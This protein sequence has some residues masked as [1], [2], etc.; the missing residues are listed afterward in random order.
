MSKKLE[1]LVKKLSKNKGIKFFILWLVP[2]MVLLAYFFTSLLNFYNYL[3]IFPKELILPLL[4]NALTALIIALAAYYIKRPRYFSSKLIAVFILGLLMA[5]YNDRLNSITDFYRAIIPTLTATNTD[6]PLISLSFI[7]TIFAGA[8][9]VGY[10]IEKY[11]IRH[12]LSW[13]HNIVYLILIVVGVVFGGQALRLAGMMPDLITQSKVQAPAL[14]KTG[15]SIEK[16]KPDVYYII[17]DRY[18]NNKVLSEQYAFDNS[19]FTNNLKNNGFTVNEAAYSN[20]PVTTPS[21]SSTLNAQYTK[22]VVEK[23][24]KNP[25]Q[26]RTLYHNLIQQ[27]SVIKAFKADGYSYHHIGSVYGASYEAPLADK[28]Y[29]HS[30]VINI[31]DK[32]T[33]TLRGI[34]IAQF[35]QSPYYQFFKVNLSWWPFKDTELDNVNYVKAQL[36]SLNQIADTKAGGRLVFA[37]ILVPH[38]PF[39]FNPDGS[40]SPYFLTDTMGK[41]IKTKYLD[42]LN[43][44]NTQVS[45]IIEKI[46][47]N[48]NNQAVIILNAD[49]GAYPQDMNN[50]NLTPIDTTGVLEKQDMTKWPNDWL[51]MKFGILQA[52]YIP[53]ASSQDLAKLNSVNVF[54]IVLNNYLGYKLDYLPNCTYAFNDGDQYMYRYISISQKLLGQEDQVCK[55]NATN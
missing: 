37:H 29:V 42:Q 48:S 33:R 24:V 21:I 4:M 13:S 36:D 55:S 31:T 54:R 35:N 23:Y 8:L 52:A 50:T 3:E 6:M 44:I 14:Q 15:S 11:Q 34:E 46:K 17:L 28:D 41:P 16:S 25:I 49:E 51:Q 2:Y 45:K 18:T 22:S 30:S 5:A 40:S 38:D 9:F 53:K 19:P 1:T 32:F 20:Y 39:S 47:K 27:S 43:F 7:I 10:L 26:S 12:K